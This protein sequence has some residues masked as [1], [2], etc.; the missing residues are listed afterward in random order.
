MCIGLVVPRGQDVVFDRAVFTFAG[1]SA[2]LPH[3]VEKKHVLD[4][5]IISYHNILK[6]KDANVEVKLTSF[7]F[8]EKVR[9]V[10][11]TSC[12]LYK[13]DESFIIMKKGSILFWTLNSNMFVID[14]AYNMG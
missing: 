3:V 9:N 5:L 7:Y 6:K 12:Q 4:L 13:T 11:D 2:Q 8:L 1:T 10:S 14:C